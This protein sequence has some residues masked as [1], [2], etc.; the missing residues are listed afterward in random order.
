MTTSDAWSVRMADTV[1]ARWASLPAAWNHEYGVLFKALLDVWRRT[2]DER[3]YGYVKRSVDAVI[4]ADGAIAGYELEHF[5]L[6]HL[7]SGRLLFPLLESTEDVRYRLAIG[8][9]REQYCRH[10]RNGA[11]GFWHNGAMPRQM[12]LDGTYMGAPFYAECGCAENDPAAIDDALLQIFLLAEHNRD[13]GTGLF[14]QGWDETRTQSWANPRTGC[15]GSFWGRATGW[16]AMA[17][18][19][20]LEIVPAGHA[21]RAELASVFKSLLEALACVQDRASGLWWNVLD[22][23]GREGNYLEASAS[24]MFLYAFARGI[25]LGMLAEPR[26]RAVLDKGFDGAL[27]FL[28]REEE[29][30]LLSVLH[31]CKTAGLGGRPG[32]DGSFAYYNSEPVVENDFKGVAAFILAANA[33][34][35]LG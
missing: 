24:L 4:D 21:R 15:S 7:N 2:G 6:D 9:L 35:A 29:D 28:L 8:T 33:R 3:Y 16:Y 19:D 20:L 31:V 30:G 13:A 11:G 10:P 26:F 23:G 12:L 25:G 22:Q 1:L 27:Q 14:F 5:S 17:M 18:A 34:E 32:R